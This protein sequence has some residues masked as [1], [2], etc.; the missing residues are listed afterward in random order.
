MP[1]RQIENRPGAPPLLAGQISI[2]DV[3]KEQYDLTPSSL[4]VGPFL[5]PLPQADA[6]TP[7]ARIP[8]PSR[9]NFASVVMTKRSSLPR[10]LG[11]T[12]LRTGQPLVADIRS[13][14]AEYGPLTRSGMGVEAPSIGRSNS[15][16]RL[17]PKRVPGGGGPDR[18]AIYWILV[19]AVAIARNMP[20]D[21]RRWIPLDA[22]L[23]CGRDNICCMDREQELILAEM[24]ADADRL[25]GLS[26]ERPRLPSGSAGFL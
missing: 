1:R 9:S 3:L 11:G 14:Q 4:C 23:G 17:P 15:G 12:G 10:F 2:D 5:R 13:A 6:T 25:Q 19:R 24:D 26:L 16:R 18:R 20:L 7:P 21:R 8:R 22:R